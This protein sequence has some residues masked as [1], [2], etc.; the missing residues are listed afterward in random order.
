MRAGQTPSPRHIFWS[1]T[2]LLVALLLAAQAT[3][4]T[5]P[6]RAQGID[7]TPYR[8]EGFLKAKSPDW[9]LVGNDLDGTRAVAVNSQTEIINKAGYPVEVGAWVIVFAR[10]VAGSFQANLIQIERPAGATAIPIQLT[11]SVTKQ[12]DGW[13]RV[14]ATVLWVTPETTG[15]AD[16]GLG[17]NVSVGAVL[18]ETGL[19]AEWMRVLPDQVIVEFSGTL[20]DTG[21]G[22]WIVDGHRVEVSDTTTIDGVP[23]PGMFVESR[24]FKSDDGRLIALD[25]KVGPPSPSTRK[26]GTIIEMRS[27]G[28]DAAMWT[29][30]LDQ[31]E[32]GAPAV[33]FVHV[34][35]NTWVDQTRA[36]AEAGQ[37]F[38]LRGAP[39]GPDS[40]QADLLRVEHGA[41]TVGTA[42]IG[43]S[44][45]H[46][47]SAAPWSAPTT[48]IST[49]AS[50]EGAMIAY[51]GDGAAHAI[52]ETD[53]RLYAAHQDASGTWST[54]EE[55][56]YGF[57]P[58][59][60]ADD[61][62]TLHVAFVNSFMNNF[63]TYYVVRRDGQWSLP[64]NMSH[65][66]GYSAR[67]KLALSPGGVLNAVWMDYT[68]GYWTTYH[69]TWTEPFW[70]ARPIPS[71]R[72][73]AP[74]LAV[75][76]DGTVYT[77]W[78]DRVSGGG[79]AL[80]D[81]EV[82]VAGLRDEIWTPPVD[83]SDSRD[84]NTLGPDI[85]VTPD[86]LAH[87]VWIE[88][89]EQVR[90]SYGQAVSWSMPTL[91]ATAVGYAN[92]VRIATES[93]SLVHVAWDE[94][95][96]VRATYAPAGSQQWPA[97]YIVVDSAALLRDVCL[98]ANPAGGVGL[99][100]SLTSDTGDS[101]IFASKREPLR[102]H[103][104][105][106]PMTLRG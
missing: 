54:P 46:G 42:A 39:T 37:W 17:S 100:W 38:R 44:M 27:E 98:S 105:W 7:G 4:A 18:T 76:N 74:S 102:T 47:A 41:Q 28:Q 81:Y 66:S 89:D 82:F 62:G 13:W 35:K 90:Y 85:T 84:I 12:G 45:P 19:R 64:V 23:E 68:P 26:T 93:G 21:P 30:L 52:W 8:F 40:Y 33:S 6:A 15:S 97:S 60:I 34:D 2:A 58:Y 3:W 99:S 9:W 29:V 53:D 65:T 32:N 10:R 48:V 63:E 24:A 87:V 71:G 96:V 43:G 72:G 80:G 56:A 101:T 5:I 69:A 11:G 55:V 94:E 70:S 31:S 59:M 16:A 14:G 83:I 61:Q 20:Q 25:L 106:V 22:Y 49:P 77:V 88:G 75:A 91:V 95:Y 1:L 104:I 51:T 73:E 67:P 36:I 92:G 103:R 50:T 86:S 79:T 78:Q 57:A